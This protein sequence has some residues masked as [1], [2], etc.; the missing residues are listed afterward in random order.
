LA[1]ESL[2]LPGIFHALVSLFTL[3]V[4][5]DP[6]GPVGLDLLVLNLLFCDA[7]PEGSLLVNF[8]Q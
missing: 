3:V 7:G 6:L 8:N 2:P 4:G 1:A 5:V